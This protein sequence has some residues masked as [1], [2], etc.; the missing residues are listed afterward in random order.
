MLGALLPV[1]KKSNK[2]P[3]PQP[4]P[5]G[6]RG[7]LFTMKCHDEYKA[8]MVEF[9]ETFKHTPSALVDLALEE[10]AKAKGFRKPPKR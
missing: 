8:W 9:A 4:N 6:R 5:A 1:T 3:G 2:K 10:L 7:S